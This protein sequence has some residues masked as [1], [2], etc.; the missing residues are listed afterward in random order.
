MREEEEKGKEEKHTLTHT[1]THTRSITSMFRGLRGRQTNIYMPN[2]YYASWVIPNTT[3]THTLNLNT[4]QMNDSVDG[5]ALALSQPTYGLN[6]W[7]ACTRTHAR[8][9]IIHRCIQFANLHQCMR[10]RVRMNSHLMYILAAVH[11]ISFE[12]RAQQ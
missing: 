7:F 8:T 10:E 1:P 3:H 6:I 12:H 4:I 5:S 9:H 2:G 11:I